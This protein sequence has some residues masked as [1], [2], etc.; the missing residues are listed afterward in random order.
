MTTYGEADRG[1]SDC[2]AEASETAPY[3]WYPPSRRVVVDE[4]EIQGLSLESA[5]CPTNR[6]SINV[7]V[8]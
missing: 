4:G 2:G 7:T 6:V 3:P 1:R 8:V 5:Y